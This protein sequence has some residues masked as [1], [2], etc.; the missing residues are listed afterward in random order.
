MAKHRNR[1]V[2]DIE[3]GLLRELKK[4]AVAGDVSLTEFVGQI[5]ETVRPSLGDLV[6]V[7]RMA[8]MQKSEAFDH[9]L[10]MSG[11]ASVDAG[12]LTLSI[13]E[14]RKGVKGGGGKST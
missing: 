11:K 1:L 2:V 9:L 3:P 10:A 14:A 13:N 12:Q 6:K 8:K 4:A 5:L 7:F